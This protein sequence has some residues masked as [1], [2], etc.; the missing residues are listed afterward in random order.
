MA[1]RG[2]KVFIG[3]AL[4]CVGLMLLGIGGCVGFTVWLSRPG[5]LL[6]AERL[7]GPATTGML[8]LNLRLEDPGTQ[9]FVEVLLESSQ[10]LNE[11]AG[12]QMPPTFRAWFVK[13]QN[14]SNEKSI[15]E[16]LPMSVVWT[17]HPDDSVDGDVHLFS[18]SVE[19]FGNRLAFMD[20][21]MGF[22]FRLSPDLVAV[23][24]GDE[25]IYS[26]HDDDSDFEGAA[27]VRDKDLFLASSVESAKRALD[28]LR[29]EAGNRSSGGVDVSSYLEELPDLPLR[30]AFSNERGE[31]Y[32]LWMR[33]LNADDEDGW[34]EEPWSGIRAMLLSGGF[35]DETSVEG[36]IDLVCKDAE[37]AEAHA[38]DFAGNIR[39]GDERGDVALTIEPTAIGD[40]IRVNFR[41]DDLTGWIDRVEINP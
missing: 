38:A 26:I 40:R 33:I 10:R 20:W 13:S 6:E 8:E 28:L 11:Q 27:F 15:E 31:A 35:V 17:I 23:R 5:E 12:G 9:H 41:I 14:R 22:V 2:K 37:W 3:C 29:G 7:V 24:H 39:L 34:R 16:L 4:G 19:R 25:R 32:R 1:S 21:V 36:Y 18:I 30:G